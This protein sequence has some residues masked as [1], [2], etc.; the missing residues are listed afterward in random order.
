MFDTEESIC[1]LS[2]V[3]NTTLL[4]DNISSEPPTGTGAF[5]SK[6]VVVFVAV[7]LEHVERPYVTVFEEVVT[8]AGVLS[9]EIALG[10]VGHDAVKD[11]L[12]PPFGCAS[13][14][15]DKAL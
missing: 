2:V 7:L 9:L 15:V 8:M 11:I 6:N 13:F 10:I 4:P 14:F 12:Q 1:S 3:S 5:F